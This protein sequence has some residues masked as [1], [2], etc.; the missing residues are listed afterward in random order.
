MSLIDSLIVLF[1]I[2]VIAGMVMVTIV[3]WRQFRRD[4]RR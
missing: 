3:S 4:P 2:A 1:E